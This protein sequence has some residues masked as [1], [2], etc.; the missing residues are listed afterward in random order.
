MAVISLIILVVI[1][2]KTRTFAVSQTT[3][4]PCFTTKGSLWFAWKLVHLQ[5]RKQPVTRDVTAQHV[6]ICLKTR[7][8]A[9]SQTTSLLY[10]F[11]CTLLWFAWK[12]VHLQY[13]K[14]L[15]SWKIFSNICCDLLENSYICSIA[16]NV[17]WIGGRHNWVVI[18]LKTRTFA[19][20]QTT[21]FFA[22]L[23]VRQLWFA[24]K[25]VHLQY[26]KQLIRIVF[27][28]QFVVI[29]LK[30]RTFAVSQTTHC[31]HDVCT[32]VLWF[33][34]KLVHL[35]YR[36]QHHQK[37]NYLNQCCDLLENSYICSIANNLK[38]YI[39]MGRIVVIC[40]KTRTFAVS[41]TTVK[42]KMVGSHRCDLLENSY[43]CSIANN[44]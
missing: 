43:I 23:Q 44:E 36:K 32:N 5:Y 10:L 17:V 25:L 27:V 26:R 12:L 37:A 31:W 41:Q 4:R 6:V 39:R 19:V 15:F 18:C 35:Q 14:Q 11:I 13:R 2:L 33:A 30:T 8:F 7:T 22:T 29:C 38:W 42:I 34:W 24:W 40:L 1:C 28:V 16:N 21:F 20:S 3:P 9:V